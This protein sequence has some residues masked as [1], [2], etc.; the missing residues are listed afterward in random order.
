MRSAI[1]SGL[2]LTLVISLV[3]INRL[4]ENGK[5]V[6]TLDKKGMLKND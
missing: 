6:G 5:K 1:T 2:S 4:G 3:L